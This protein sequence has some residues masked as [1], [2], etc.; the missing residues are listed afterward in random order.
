VWSSPVARWLHKPKAASSNLATAIKFIG[1]SNVELIGD[2]L[3]AEQHA[4]ITKKLFEIKADITAALGQ[5]ALL[6]LAV[7]VRPDGA[8]PEKYQGTL[9]RYG[10][11]LITQ[12]DGTLSESWNSLADHT[13][14][15]NPSNSPA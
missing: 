15:L 8:D 11:T 3:N 7:C 1:A 12:R 4:S 9:N 5:E 14:N 10:G 2:K 6:F 13:L